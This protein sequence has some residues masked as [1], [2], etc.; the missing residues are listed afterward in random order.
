MCGTQSLPA[1]STGAEILPYPAYHWIKG[2]GYRLCIKWPVLPL[3]HS[4]ICSECVL[5]SSP[6]STVCLESRDAGG[7]LHGSG[8]A[9][10]PSALAPSR[11]NKK[12]KGS[13]CLV[14]VSVC[15]KQGGALAFLIAPLPA[16]GGQAGLVQ[17]RKGSGLPQKLA[18][19][20]SGLAA[21]P[22]AE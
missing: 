11:T 20:G 12:R 9:A 8:V 22:A 3:G 18:R 10:I 1:S 14:N 16:P 4:L 19:E 6:H 21:V 5:C 2:T 17:R 13:H 15:K 7:Q